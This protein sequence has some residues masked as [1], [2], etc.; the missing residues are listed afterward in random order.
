MAIWNV[1]MRCP[2]PDKSVWM[3]Q[4]VVPNCWTWQRARNLSSTCELGRWMYRCIVGWCAAGYAR[5]D[6]ER[7][8]EGL[9]RRAAPPPQR[10]LHDAA[11]GQ[12]RAL[13]G[14]RWVRS[15]LSCSAG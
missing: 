12:A 14:L 2:H 3:S 1:L 5:R 10:L 8:G 9:G 6:G 15:R 7:G 13:R 4:V 11:A